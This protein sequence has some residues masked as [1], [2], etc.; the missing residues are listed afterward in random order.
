MTVTIKS[1]RGDEI[2]VTCSAASGVMTI[3]QDDPNDVRFVI[4]RDY[5]TAD[6]F[7]SSADL[8]TVIDGLQ[9]MLKQVQ[10][11]G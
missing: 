7:V 5:N 10:A 9:Q 11:N 1:R 4:E 6:V 3:S 2:R 8:E